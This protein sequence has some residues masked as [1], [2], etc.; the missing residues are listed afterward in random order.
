MI[1]D[2][3][4]P[5]GAPPNALSEAPESR[6]SDAQSVEPSL[7][8][9]TRSVV[10]SSGEA[11]AVR[12]L[13]SQAV[14]GAPEGDAWDEH[15]APPLRAPAS[16]QA[17]MAGLAPAADD[18]Q[19]VD[20]DRFARGSLLAKRE[21]RRGA[22]AVATP[23]NYEARD[24]ARGR[25]IGIPRTAPPPPNTEPVLSSRSAG[26]Y[27]FVAPHGAVAEE[28][29]GRPPKPAPGPLGLSA[30]EVNGAPVAHLAPASAS[31]RDEVDG[32]T[33]TDDNGAGTRSSITNLVE[34]NT[35][36]IIDMG[37]QI[38]ALVE[39]LMA[40]GPSEELSEIDELVQ[41][42]EAVLP[43]VVQLFPGPLWFDRH[44]PYKR[45]PRGRDV[46]ALARAVVAFGGA[47]APYLASKL[48]SDD[49]E[50]VYYAILVA[51]EIP[52]LD[53]LDG[54]ARR[55]LDPDDELR[56]VALEA[57]R[58]FSTLPQLDAVVRAFAQL[59]QR[60]GKDPRRQ[61]LALEALAELRDPRALAAL[62]P[63]LGDDSEAI[64]QA[65]HRGLVLLTAQ[66]FG[67]AH[68]K[69]ES[70]VEQCS[71]Q[72]RVEWLVD[73]LMHP[74]EGL[75]ALAGEEIKQLTQQYFG[76][77]PQLPKRDREVAQRKYR[78][79]WENEGRALF[80][81]QIDTDQIH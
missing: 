54:V 30:A 63:R 57:L 75:R 74:D 19:A 6:P 53:L 35:S 76:Y 5:V 38:T 61:R 42:G 8:E 73:S 16:R 24:A 25:L 2:T 41:I 18:L 77:H 50:V 81:V 68:R 58:Y 33:P 60:P 20:V 23:V 78:E 66:D 69:W 34:D 1:V 49:P 52:H 37:D 14:A 71:Q 59:S 45:R 46:S 4:R 79:W 27:S 47:A 11:T 40:A 29:L 65:A 56:A 3:S 80:R 36:V 55:A 21:T 31:E 10:E 13:V 7:A 22:T 26:G 15:A 51:A 39:S 72:H 12:P 70:W 28:S 32:G 44:K 62:L 9:E 17:T 64:V 67:L 43:V 48:S